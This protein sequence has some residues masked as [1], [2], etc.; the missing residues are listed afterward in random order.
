MNNDHIGTNCLGNTSLY[1]YIKNDTKMF[2]KSGYV[3][4]ST[5]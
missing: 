1:A 3:I 4:Y 5:L 2:P